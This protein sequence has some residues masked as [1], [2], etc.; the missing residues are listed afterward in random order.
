MLVLNLKKLKCLLI[1][2]NCLNVI[3]AVV[4]VDITMSM[5]IAVVAKVSTIMKME[6]VAAEV[7]TSMN[8]VKAVVVEA[9]IITIIMRKG[10][11]VAAA[12]MSTSMAKVAAVVDTTI[13][14]IMK[15]VNVIAGKT[16]PNNLFDG[17]R[18][19]RL[20]IHYEC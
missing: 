10:S 15:M 13:T 9:T 11:V 18:F 20:F 14:I 16:K 1:Q 5:G 6:N 3:M 19:A 17:G 8:T 2:L 4:A 7:I 12:I